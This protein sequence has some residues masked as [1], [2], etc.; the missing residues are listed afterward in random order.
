MKSWE[1]IVDRLIFKVTSGRFVFTIVVAGVFAYLACNQILK[2]DRVMEVTLVVLYAY[3]SK[4]RSEENG[5]GK[6]G[7][8]GKNGD[9]KE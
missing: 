1:E 9:T 2:E 7:K 5:N 3:F 8:N 6:N 4:I